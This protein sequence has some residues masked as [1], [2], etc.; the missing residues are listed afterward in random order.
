VNPDGSIDV[1]GGKHVDGTVQVTG[2][3]CTSC[4]G[5]PNRAPVAGADVYVQAAPPLDTKG[6]T[7]GRGVGAHLAHVNRRQMS[8]PLSCATCHVVPSLAGHP[9]GSVNVTFAGIATEGGATPAWIPSTLTCS[10]T[11]CHR[12]SPRWTDGLMSCSS[13]HTTPTTEYHLVHNR[14]NR[15]HDSV[16]PSGTVIVVPELHVNGTI[17]TRDCAECH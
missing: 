6:A 9:D 7:T 4:H 1:A 12:G 14:C 2:G 5:D 8:A 13:C 11:Y 15:C 10:S 17:E 3:S 16:D